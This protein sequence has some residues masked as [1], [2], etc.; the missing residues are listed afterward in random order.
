MLLNN[1]IVSAVYYHSLTSSNC[2]IIK[3]VKKKNHLWLN[4]VE[5]D[6]SD[7]EQNAGLV[8]FTEPKKRKKETH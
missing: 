3:L 6:V 1:I 2:K 5:G 7:C 4:P 8:I